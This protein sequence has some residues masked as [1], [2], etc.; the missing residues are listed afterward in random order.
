MNQANIP[1]IGSESVLFALKEI[2][3]LVAIC[4]GVLVAISS[5]LFID[6]RSYRI[7]KGRRVMIFH[8]EIR[9]AR[10]DPKL[11]QIVLFGF[12]A[13]HNRSWKSW[14]CGRRPTKTNSLEAILSGLRSRMSDT[15]SPQGICLGELL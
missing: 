4:K 9:W 7:I 5:P 14:P 11:A 6:S 1:M 15:V 13:S 3:N 8:C 2:D 12:N 10:A